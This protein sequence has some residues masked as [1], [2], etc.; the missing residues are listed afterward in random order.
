MLRYTCCGDRGFVPIEVSQIVLLGEIVLLPILD[1]DFPG[2][3]RR[4]ESCAH[5]P[6]TRWHRKKDK[7]LIFELA[8]FTLWRSAEACVPTQA[9]PPPLAS[10]N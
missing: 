6:Q 9:A 2:P 1:R 5:V 7:T 4:G 10:R 8:S 3:S